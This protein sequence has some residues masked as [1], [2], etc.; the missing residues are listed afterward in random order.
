MTR[1]AIVAASEELRT[2]LAEALRAHPA[3]EVVT[4]SAS[5]SD[6]APTAEAI[7]VARAVNHLSPIG[8]PAP[9]DTAGGTLLTNREREILA[10]L[11]DGLGNKQIATRLGI[12]P[13]TVKTHLE[14]LFEKLR[15]SS[16]AE[17][18]ATGVKRGLLLL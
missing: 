1:I 7:L 8:R 12:S 17:A 14:L 2:A 13:N 15:V 18:V 3:F 6:A 9:D 16:R 5:I 11:A 4:V 10:L